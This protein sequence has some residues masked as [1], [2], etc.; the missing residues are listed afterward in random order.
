M[1][2][3]PVRL[4]FALKTQWMIYVA[5][6]KKLQ[7][8]TPTNNVCCAAEILCLLTSTLSSLVAKNSQFLEWQKGFSG[9]FE[10]SKDQY[11]LKDLLNQ[12]EIELRGADSATREFFSQ[13]YPF[14]G[15]T[16]TCLTNH[17]CFASFSQEEILKQKDW[18]IFSCYKINLKEI[19][20]LPKTK[21]NRS[22][23][24]FFVVHFFVSV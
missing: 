10:G 8:C 18:N 21:S 12:R 15:R 13:K 5:K 19:N 17:D 22:S 4:S 23:L 7:N 2:W 11:F 3:P 24:Q 20:I 1:Y 9:A 6:L 14:Q 16:K